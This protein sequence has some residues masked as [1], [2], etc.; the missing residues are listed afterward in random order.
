MKSAVLGNSSKGCKVG[1]NL[2]P[3]VSAAESQLS[4]EQNTR[5]AA[6]HSAPTGNASTAAVSNPGV[7]NRAQQW[8]Q[9]QHGRDRIVVSTLRCG[10][11]NLGSNPSHGRNTPHKRG[12]NFGWWVPSDLTLSHSGICYFTAAAG[13]RLLHEPSNRA[14][15]AKKLL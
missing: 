10:R 7:D 11:S 1:F 9:A 5:R 13:R 14:E 4:E 3:S 8:H 6:G 2:D 12:L 15:G